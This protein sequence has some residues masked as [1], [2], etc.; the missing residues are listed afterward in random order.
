MNLSKLTKMYSN[1]S[2]VVE[3]HPKSSKLVPNRQKSSKLIEFIKTHSNFENSLKKKEKLIQKEKFTAFHRYFL[4]MNFPNTKQTSRKFCTFRFNWMGFNEFDVVFKWT[5]SSSAWWSFNKSLNGTH[6]PWF[7][8]IENIVIYQ[9]IKHRNQFIFQKRW[10]F[11]FSL[12]IWRI[13][14]FSSGIS[15][16]FSISLEFLLIFLYWKCFKYLFNEQSL[17]EISLKSATDAKLVLWY[18][19][20]G[21]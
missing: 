14:S 19:T 21:E 6:L 12:K 13:L 10:K 9:K 2:K 20:I 5:N 4:T 11:F 16:N 17:V 3:N 18:C 7:V 1:L 8:D 15:V